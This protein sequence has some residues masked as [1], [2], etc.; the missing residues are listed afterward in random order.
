MTER[1][2]DHEIQRGFTDWADIVDAHN[3]DCDAYEA[4]IAELEAELDEMSAEV[5]AAHFAQAELA[6]VKAE[7]L[8]VVV[9]GEAVGLDAIFNSKLDFRMNYMADGVLMYNDGISMKSLVCHEFEEIGDD[10][11]FQ[12]VRL[13]RWEAQND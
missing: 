3:A 1:W 10:M 12:P 9:D 7:S 11:E 8:R 5:V 13:E 6:R 4:R 2:T